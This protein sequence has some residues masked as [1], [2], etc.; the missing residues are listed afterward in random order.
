MSKYYLPVDSHTRNS[1]SWCHD[2]I[3]TNRRTNKTSSKMIYV[4]IFVVITRLK[5]INEI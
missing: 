2:L 1:S 4:I 3:K 5:T